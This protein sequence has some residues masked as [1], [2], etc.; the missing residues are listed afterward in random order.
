VIILANRRFRLEPSRLRLG[1]CWTEL[2]LNEL[3]RT[4]HALLILPG[5]ASVRECPQMCDELKA[6][7]ARIL[8]IQRKFQTRDKRAKITL[9]VAWNSGN[10]DYS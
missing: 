7:Q 4:R 1:N 3:W 8:P 10:P 6:I 2:D 5:L 9:E